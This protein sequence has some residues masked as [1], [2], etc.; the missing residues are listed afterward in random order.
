M[1]LKSFLPSLLL[2]LTLQAQI[3]ITAG[4]LPSAGELFTVSQSRPQPNLNF[5]STG[6]N[7]TWDFS[8]LPADTQI[9]VEWKS[10]L[11]VPQYMISCGNANFQA[12][13]LKVADSLP[14]PTVS[15][16]DLYVFLR[17]SPQQM[18][19]HG[20]GLT[21]NGVPIT[22]CYRDPD[23]IYVLP[24]SYLREDS[25][26]FW[27]RLQIPLPAGGAVTFAQ[28]GYRLHKADGYG[29]LRTPYGTFSVLRLYR[30]NY[31][32]DT[33]YLNGI[34]VQSRDSSY[35][36]LEWLGQGAGIPLLRVTGSFSRLGG[37]F[38]FIPTLIQFK[39]EPRSSSL[40]IGGS[41]P[42]ITPNPCRGVLYIS[43]PG[44]RYVL[45]N[46]IGNVVAEGEVPVD[47]V[48]RLAS[49]LPEGIYFIRLWY[50][51]KEYWHRFA[52]VREG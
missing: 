20:I 23:E 8:Q 42:S 18:T 50:E 44:Q 26:T 40:L 32:R 45:Y 43:A 36:E 51:G 30:E 16:R 28:R 11:Q 1:S 21:A 27:L 22:E 48:L 2:G 25:T 12:L 14:T 34:P 15:V 5:L 10:P 29:Q 4:D 17:K 9:A 6:A 19:V 3:Q 13:F 41:K 31:Q 39:D 37:T 33:V 47:G 46:L 35:L 7:Y 24:L 52:L 38:T 49:D